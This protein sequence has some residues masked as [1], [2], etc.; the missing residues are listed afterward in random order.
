[1]KKIKLL[2]ILLFLT[3][4]CAQGQLTM[5]NQTNV[6]NNVLKVQKDANGKVYTIKAN[7]TT[8]QAYDFTVTL[9][10]APENLVFTQAF[11][12]YE[13]DCAYPTTSKL[14]GA[15]SKF[16]HSIPLEVKKIQ[17]NV[18]H[19]TVYGD[20]ILNEDYQ[21]TRKVCNWKL[22][23]SSMV[24]EPSPNLSMRGY[25]ASIW[26]NKKNQVNDYYWRLEGYILLD[27]FNLP[28]KRDDILVLDIFEK[29]TK[30]D[31]TDN[32]ST[33]LVELRSK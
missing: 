22:Q 25:E 13:S 19:A 31:Y 33:V 7:P 26:L 27:D 9:T 28:K 24:F 11:A 17:D 5:N 30:T 16:R 8:K 20:A 1:M 15:Y 12:E 2:T 18:Y 3:T 10:N 6:S 23:Y 4:S 21:N 32:V 29:I 14:I